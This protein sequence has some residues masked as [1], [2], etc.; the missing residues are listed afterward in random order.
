[1]IQTILIFIIIF[2]I[3]VII[4]EFGHF[5]FAKRAGILVREFAIGMGPKVFS[6]RKNGT[7]YT[8][9]IFPLGGYVRM[10][11]YG[12]DTNELRAGMPIKILVNEQNNITLINLSDKEQI[13]A[14]P[15]EITQFDL[16]EAMFLEGMVPGNSAPVRYTVEREALIVEPDGTE[17]QV[18]PI[19]VQFQSASLVN[20]MLTNFAGPMNN[21]ILGVVV[22][23]VL[24][25]IQGGV[26]SDANKL[27]EVIS[28][29]VAE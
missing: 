19:D 14:I 18:A 15:M 8:V 20:R 17:V 21:F 10:A 27:G 24:A 29:G 16:D 26:A 6:H 4:H 2:S 13:H 5:Y 23:S 1:M 9:R 7:T 22:F 28:G 3:L 11:G 12:D 25:F